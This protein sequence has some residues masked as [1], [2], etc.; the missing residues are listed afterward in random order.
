MASTLQ[1]RASSTISRTLNGTRA[2]TQHHGRVSSHLAKAKVLGRRG[3][4]TIIEQGQEGWRLRYALLY[5]SFVRRSSDLIP[6]LSLGKDPV[7]LTPGLNIRIPLYHTL[8]VL[9][10]RESS[11]NIP[12]V[13][14]Q[15]RFVL[16]S[17]LA[18][19]FPQLPGYT[20]DNVI[21]IFVFSRT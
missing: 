18:N 17:P 21:F 16:L 7:K 10:I 20:A 13:C 5:F 6:D 8:T 1:N 14:L 11:V 4:F 15:I 12:N 9:D 3:F 19:F 2:L